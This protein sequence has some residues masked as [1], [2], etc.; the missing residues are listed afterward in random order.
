LQEAAPEVSPEVV[1]MLLALLSAAGI[2]LPAD[3][4][5]ETEEEKL[6]HLAPWAFHDLLFHARSRPGRSDEPLGKT[7]PFRDRFPPL[8]AVRPPA[9]PTASLLPLHRPDL[10]ALRA[11]DPP[12]T[13]VLEGRR[14]RRAQA[15]DPISVEALGELLYRAA[16]VSGPSPWPVDATGYETTL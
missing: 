10:E 14:S 2:A 6:P 12:F 3:G 5:G 16:R 1:A 4:Q 7:F 9:D 11:S 15:P 13:A 8:P